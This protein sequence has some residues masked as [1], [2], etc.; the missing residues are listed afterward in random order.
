[1]GYVGSDPDII[2]DGKTNWIRKYI[3]TEDGCSREPVTSYD[4]NTG[5]F[6]RPG[7]PAMPTT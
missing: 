7:M 4:L 5:R 1:M 6:R 2:D 3:S